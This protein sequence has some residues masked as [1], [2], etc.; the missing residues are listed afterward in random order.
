MLF[1]PSRLTDTL[2][3]VRAVSCDNVKRCG[4][5]G[6]TDGAG[7]GS[8]GGAGG[9]ITTTTGAGLGAGGTG[10]GGGG[11]GG[12]GVGLISTTFGGG[13]GGAGGCTGVTGGGALVGTTDSIETS[14]TCVL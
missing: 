13:R 6:T 11:A 12:G 7:F 14:R 9:G 1:L 2:P 10:T 3:Q 8:I 5:G 4:A